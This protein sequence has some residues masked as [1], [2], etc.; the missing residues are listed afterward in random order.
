VRG[1]KREETLEEAG[2]CAHAGFT[3]RRLRCWYAMEA[4]TEEGIHGGDGGRGNLAR[5]GV[6]EEI[7]ARCVASR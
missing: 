1:T 3:V 7:D 4:R 2:R 6:G 5:R